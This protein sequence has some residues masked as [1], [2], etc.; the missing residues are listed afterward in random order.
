MQLK[1]FMKQYTIDEIA[2]L[3]SDI[4]QVESKLESLPDKINEILG[5]ILKT[6]NNDFKKEYQ[7]K[8]NEQV[9]ITR[10]YL[11]QVEIQNEQIDEIRNKIEQLEK[12]LKT[13]PQTSSKNNILAIAISSVLSSI[14]TIS[15]TL[16]CLNIFIK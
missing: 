12:K 4:S 1:N 15:I 14:L 2:Q 10:A 11:E 6:F 9:S 8:L 16:V 5:I 3:N 7:D 13:S